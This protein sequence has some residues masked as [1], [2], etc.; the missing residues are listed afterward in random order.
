MDTTIDVIP[1]GF[2]NMFPDQSPTGYPA[3]NYGNACSQYWTTTNGTAT[4]MLTSCDEIADDIAFCQSQGKII[5]A[6]LGGAFPGGNTISSRASAISFARFLWG[7]FGP[8]QQTD[9]YPRPFGTSVVDGFDFDMETGSSLGYV[10]LANELRRLSETDPRRKYHLS[11]SP[12]CPIPDLM[13]AQVLENS[14]VDFV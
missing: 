1:I 10:D 2:V 8:V 3:T 14:V 9:I 4:N 5:L 6:S 13:M 11:C 7:S 12:Q